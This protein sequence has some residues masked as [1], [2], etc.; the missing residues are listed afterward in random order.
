VVEKT[1]TVNDRV[2]KFAGAHPVRLFSKIWP[3][4]LGLWVIGCVN[5]RVPT[6]VTFPEPP[7]E[8]VRAQIGPIAL[9]T[10]AT[11]ATTEFTRPMGKGRSVGHGGWVGFWTPPAVLASG[12]DGRGLILGLFLSPVAG[13]AGAIYGAVAGMNA[14]EY[15]QIQTTLCAVLQTTDWTSQLQVAIADSIRQLTSQPIVSSTNVAQTTLELTPLLIRLQ[16]A[17]EIEPPLTFVGTV[18]LRLLCPM[19]QSELFVTE[20]GY[21]GSQYRLREWAEHDGELFRKELAT[22]RSYLSDQIAERVFLTY[23]LPESPAQQRVL[24]WPPKK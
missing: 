12:G 19:D 5:P 7:P 21:T 6:Y 3:I 24:P 2:A 13:T 4:F 9:T 8:E 10:A 16:G 18:R 15:E 1:L 14:V 11:P 23:S 17:F 20:F 22:A